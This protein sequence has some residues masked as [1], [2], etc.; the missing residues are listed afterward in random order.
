LILP[1][2]RTA[3]LFDLCIRRASNRVDVRIWY[4]TAPVGD[5]SY[6]VE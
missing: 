2:E 1:S 3:S 4:G 6:R 5:K